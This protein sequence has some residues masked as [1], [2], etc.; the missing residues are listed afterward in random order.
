M[1]VQAPHHATQ[2]GQCATHHKHADKQAFDAVAQRFHHLAVLH[3]GAN[4]QANFGAGERPCQERKHCQAHHH[5]QQ[6]VFF[7]GGIAQ[8][9]R[10]AHGFG[11]GQRQLRGA[12]NHFDEL[13]AND[14]AAHGD[15]NLFQM[16]TIDRAHDVALKG[17][18][19]SAR[20][21]HGD[22]HGR[23]DGNQ[24]A[25]QILRAS[26]ITHQAQHC[27]GNKSA[28]CNEHSMA[29]IQH[30]HQ[31][32]YQRQT[33]RNDENDHAHGQSSHGQSQPRG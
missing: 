30:I 11:Q 21:Q 29:K 2:T 12:P 8:E 19:H 5:R 24:I 20:H 17:K 25:P 27:G 23:E 1:L 22:Q 26:P 15:Q 28:Q 6:A 3:T 9:H 16:L 32:K 33:R 18:S 4:Q 31:T 10:T 7:N 13:F 14:H